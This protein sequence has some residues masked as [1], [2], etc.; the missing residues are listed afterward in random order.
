MFD[1][2]KFLKCLIISLIITLVIEVVFFILG[3]SLGWFII[4]CKQGA[5]CPTEIEHFLLSLLYTAPVIF[6][7][8]FLIYYAI[9]NK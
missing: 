9:K 4:R 8:T 6:I 7:I 5:P 1:K 2:N 3:T